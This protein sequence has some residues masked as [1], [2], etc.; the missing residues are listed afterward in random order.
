MA[1]EIIAVVR[2]AEI[3]AEQ[4][5]KMAID[6]KNAIIKQ[7][8]KETALLVSTMINE[9]KYQAETALAEAKKLGSQMMKEAEAGA[10]IEIR[11][12]QEIAKRKE[13][14]IISLIIAELI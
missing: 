9:E 3:K 7:T 5:E 6:E 8:K 10:E 4:T 2:K 13:D 11:R 12:L 14:Q 1:Q